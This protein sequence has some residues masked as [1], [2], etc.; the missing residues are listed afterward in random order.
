MS[1]VPFAGFV[2]QWQQVCGAM[3]MIRCEQQLQMFFLSHAFELKYWGSE[4]LGRRGKSA[5]RESQYKFIWRSDHGA[6]VEVMEHYT[7]FYSS[8]HVIQCEF[9]LILNCRNLLTDR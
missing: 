1:L 7:W 3:V 2:M 8:A 6:P 5:S 4:P 9:I